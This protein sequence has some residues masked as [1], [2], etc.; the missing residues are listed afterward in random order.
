MKL[1]V[2]KVSKKG[3]FCG[4]KMGDVSIGDLD[5]AR[6]RPQFLVCIPLWLREEILTLYFSLKT[7]ARQRAQSKDILIGGHIR[8]LITAIC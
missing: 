7:L 8:L 1:A 3:G 5:H 4:I 6:P 2:S